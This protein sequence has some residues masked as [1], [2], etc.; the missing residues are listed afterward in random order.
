M[1]LHE[2]RRLFIGLLPDRTVQMQIQRH[3]RE[4]TWP[5]IARPTRFARYHLTLRFLGEVG[6]APESRLRMALRDVAAAP[7]QLVLDT[8]VL[9]RNDIAVLLPQESP[10]LHRLQESVAE[11]WPQAGPHFT[12]HIT[13]ARDAHGAV[14][15]AQE[16][17]IAWTISEFVLVWSRLDT[18]PAEYV[19]LER[20][21]LRGDSASAPPA[22]QGTLF[23]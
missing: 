9:W 2:P 1:Q 16:A 6:S 22:P 4:W 8:P 12:P 13:L 10:G 18:R 19:M 15:P 5:E 14:P 20:F 3:A 11:C 21:G 17:G 23:D 7:L